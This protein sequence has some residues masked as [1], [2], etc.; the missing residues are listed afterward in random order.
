M[1]RAQVHKHHGLAI[2]AQGRLQEVSQLGVAERNVRLLVGVSVLVVVLD[3]GRGLLSCAAE[4]QSR[5]NQAE[6]VH[7]TTLT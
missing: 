5:T 6:L 2:T 1:R 3:E 4:K 7:S